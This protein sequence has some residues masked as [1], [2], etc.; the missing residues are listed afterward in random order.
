MEHVTAVNLA[1][2]A[3]GVTFGV[4]GQR[5]EFCLMR[6]LQYW[7]TESDRRRIAMFALALAAA[8]VGSQAI[9]EAG[10]VDLGRSLYLRTPASWLLVPIGG[11]LFGYGMVAANGCG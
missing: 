9:S 4:L 7:W 5:T 10:L 8:V 1:G 2:L 3:I 6:G 11:I